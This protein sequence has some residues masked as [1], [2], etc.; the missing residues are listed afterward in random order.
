ML[1]YFNGAVCGSKKTKQI[2]ATLKKQPPILN[3]KKPQSLCEKT[4]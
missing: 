4:S 1:Q 3:K 2:P